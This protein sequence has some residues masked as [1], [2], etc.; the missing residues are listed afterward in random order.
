MMRKLTVVAGMMALAFGALAEEPAA[1]AR[2]QQD[3][4]VVARKHLADFFLRTRGM[5]RVVSASEVWEGIRSGKISYRVVDVRQP[6]DY[7]KGHVP[8]A[9]N[10]PLDVLFRPASLE[11]LP[12]AGDPILLV[13]QS[14]HMESMALGGLAALGYDP[15]VLRFGMIG[16]NAETKVKAAGAPGKEPDVVRGLGGPVE[17]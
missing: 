12:A 1:S 5:S 9:M 10:I 15:Y 4:A 6:E 3:D 7:E 17:R 13:C 11:K 8:G 2:A 16:W 14:G